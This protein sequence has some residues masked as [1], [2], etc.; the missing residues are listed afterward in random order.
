MSFVYFCCFS[1]KES[2]EKEMEMKMKHESF[3]G[4]LW[5]L[6]KAMGLTCLV[7]SAFKRLSVLVVIPNALHPSKSLQ[8][9]N[10]DLVRHFVKP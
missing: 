8:L 1:V 4:P 3:D 6:A 10:F 5:L 2:E 7:E 9:T